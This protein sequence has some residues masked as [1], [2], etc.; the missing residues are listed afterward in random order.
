MHGNDT[1]FAS[2]P[3]ENPFV[4]R[5]NTETKKLECKY[6][7]SCNWVESGSATIEDLNLEFSCFG[8]HRVIEVALCEL[9]L[10][11]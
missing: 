6:L 4:W 10:F 2:K 8:E 1:P 5:L 9:A 7:S 3:E 11:L